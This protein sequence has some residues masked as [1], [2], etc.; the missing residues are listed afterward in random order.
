MIVGAARF[1]LR[2]HGVQ[3]LKQK[4]SVV[5]R[6]L[7]QLRTSCPV[8]VAEVGHNDLL[9]RSLIGAC[10]VSTSEELINSV[11]RRLEAK[12]ETSGSVEMIDSEIE[13]IHYGEPLP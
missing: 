8:S 4:R 1:D 12:I 5:Q 3:S 10:I 6:L 7:H 9:Q 2:L 13:L 11:F